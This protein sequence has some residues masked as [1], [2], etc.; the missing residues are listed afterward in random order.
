MSHLLLLGAGFSRNWGGWLAGEAF[1]YLL[2][3][4]EVACNSHLQQ[5]LWRNQP[6]GGFE[7]ALAEVQA[8]FIKSPQEHT[9][10]LQ[11]IQNAVTRM[12]EDMNRG[13]LEHP[14]FE[15]QQ[16]R[17]RMVGT[18]LTRFN[19]IF[20]L[21][22]D[23]LLEHYYIDQNIT[24]LSNGRWTGSDLPGMR[25]APSGG[26]AIPNSWAERSWTPSSEDFNLAERMQ[27]Y[28]KLHGSSNWKEKHGAP[29]LI[30]GG[31]KIREIGLSPVLLWY[32]Q[33]FEECLNKPNAKLFV[34]GYG[35][36]DKHINEVI[37][38]AINENGLK[39]FVIAPEGGDLARIANPTHTAS[40]RVETSLEVAFEHGLIGAS[41]RQLSDIFGGDT[42]EFNKVMRFFGT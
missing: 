23:L 35:F 2:G 6:A 3:C 37:I 16:A 14:D 42:I 40:I 25:P 33:K 19:A 11:D 29:M 1:E 10:N 8:N 28:F 21:N 27:P 15:F 38:R 7:N 41:R 34:I 31:N 22:Q 13:F 17:E 5:L 32:H 20:T 26:T 9:K 4:P 18:F 24:L 30:M 36:R 39:M 12:F